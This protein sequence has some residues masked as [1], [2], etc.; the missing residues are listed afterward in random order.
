V[1]QQRLLGVYEELVERE[2]G[3]GAISGTQVDNL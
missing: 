2:P 1:E 3:R